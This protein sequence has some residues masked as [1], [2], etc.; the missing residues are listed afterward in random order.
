MMNFSHKSVLSILIFLPSAISLYVRNCNETLRA[1]CHFIPSPN[2]TATNY[3]G[4]NPNSPSSAYPY[5]VNAP[6]S[7]VPVATICQTREPYNSTAEL[8]CARSYINAIDEQLAFLYARRLGFAAVAGHAKFRNGTDLNDAT[9]NE[10]VAEGMADRVEK[11]GG[12]KEAGRIMGGETCQ[13][14]ASLKYEVQNI[15]E[16]CDA[17]FDPKVPRPCEDCDNCDSS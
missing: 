7:A 4:S 15:R 10:A 12:T 13:I 17:G 2:A 9:R 6:L 11:Y 16:V 3:P 1:D 14:Y 5:S 8:L